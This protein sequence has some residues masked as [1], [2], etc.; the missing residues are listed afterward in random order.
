MTK[1]D[2][3]NKVALLTGQSKSTTEKI[4]NQAIATIQ[5]AVSAGLTVSLQSFISFTPTTKKG[6][7]YEINGIKTFKPEHQSVKL[8]ASKPF[9]DLVENG[10]QEEQNEK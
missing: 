1:L 6:R 7:E 9:K 10:I 5:E 3:T 8:K 4:I 2:I